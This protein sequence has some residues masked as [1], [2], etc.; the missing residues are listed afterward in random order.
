MQIEVRPAKPEEMSEA[1]RIADETL[2]LPPGIIPEEFINKISHDMTL[3]AFVDGKMAT[4][5]ASWPFIM[6]FNGMDAPVAGVSFVGTLPVY[7]RMG[8]L[9]K[10]HSKHFKVLHEEGKRSISILFASQSAIY[11]R[12]GYSV[13]ATQNSYD[14][15]P[16]KIK[17]QYPEN[18]STA[19]TMK[20]VRENEVE[21]LNKIY[22]KF[23]AFRT[24]YLVREKFKWETGVLNPT[25]IPGAAL[26]KVVYEEDGEQ[27]GYVIYTMEPH[28]TEH[29]IV[30]KTTIRD[31]AWLTI[32]AWYGIWDF[33]TKMDLAQN[34]HWMQAPPDDPMPY[35]IQEPMELNIKSTRNLLAR[36]IDIDKAMT[37]RGYNED[38]EL[39]FKIEDDAMC[40]WNNGTWQVNIKD[41][42][43][44]IEKS[45]KAP[46]VSMNINTMAIL[47]FGQVSTSEAVKMGNM[48]IFKEDA[49]KK[50]DRLLSTEYMPF[51]CDII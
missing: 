5:Y 41:G 21:T 18:I 12:Y 38:G 9:R 10:V 13:V 16:D 17:F 47:L 4:T 8:C 15:A 34:I 51:C 31:M 29:G 27:R 2:I 48:E 26:D 36:I 49:I 42:I 11:Q 14:I 39:I 23:T 33:F 25:S 7:R 1:R 37:V 22:N 20:Q 30:Q 24:G 35:L 40:P 32:S 44:T 50:Y 46:E 45:E 43:A 19:G 3:C 28:F 6:K